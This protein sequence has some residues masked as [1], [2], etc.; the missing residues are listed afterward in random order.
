M[1]GNGLKNCYMK[2]IIISFNHISMGHNAHMRS[3]FLA[4]TK[5][6]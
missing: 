4:V 2:Q 1:V 5:L 6:E 3:K